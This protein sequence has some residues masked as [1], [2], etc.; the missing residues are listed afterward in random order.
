MRRIVPFVHEGGGRGARGHDPGGAGIRHAAD[1]AGVDRQSG[2]YGSA[3]FRSRGGHGSYRTR[4]LGGS[5]ARGAGERGFPRPHCPWPGRRSAF[6]AHPG[7][8]GADR[9]CAGDEPGHVVGFRHPPEPGRNPPPRLSRVR[10]RRRRSGL[11]RCGAGADGRA[12]RTADGLCGVVR[13]RTAGGKTFAHHRRADPGSDRSGAIPE[14]SQFGENGLCAGRGSRGGRRPRDPGQRPG[15]LARAGPRNPDRRHQRR[16]H[17]GRDHGAHRGSRRVHRRGGGGGLP[18]GEQQG[19]EN[20]E[21]RSEHEYR[22]RAQSG[23]HQR[24]RKPESTAAGG[25][26]CSG[27]RRRG[28]ERPGKA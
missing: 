8:S 10:T 5:C 14:Q 21:R 25:R 7:D 22:T 13:R 1:H 18:P 6:H 27:N 4:A 12:G 3:R 11:R 20:K 24:S 23:H 15:G 16:R 28:R 19:R 17:A 9:A 2:A 26:L